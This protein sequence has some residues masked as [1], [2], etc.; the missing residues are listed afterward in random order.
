MTV[1]TELFHQH[2]PATLEGVSMFLT[3]L[4]GLG[5]RQS[6]NLSTAN[7]WALVGEEIST[8]IF[9]YAYPQPME[10]KGFSVKI[11]QSDQTIRMEFTD[12]GI[13]YNPLEQQAPDMDI[14]SIEDMPIGGLGVHLIKQMSD[15]LEYRYENGKNWLC[16]E[17][18]LSLS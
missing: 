10:N 15:H 2:Y 12:H 9:K 16:A 3:D 13:P 7:H 6:W 14:D 8:N 5:E 17:K 11:T 4:E 1:P 18:Q